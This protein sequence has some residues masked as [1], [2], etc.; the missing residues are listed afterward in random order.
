MEVS[1]YERLL[2][3]WFNAGPALNQHWVNSSCLVRCWGDHIR[4]ACH[5]VITQHT[6]SPPVTRSAPVRRV[7]RAPGRGDVW[8][9]HQVGLM[10]SQETIP[11]GGS[12]YRAGSRHCPRGGTPCRPDSPVIVLDCLPFCAAHG[13]TANWYWARGMF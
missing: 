7:W 10:C 6:N 4:L 3:C 1:G 13:T 11:R 8:L 2:Q 9:C 12:S 5:P